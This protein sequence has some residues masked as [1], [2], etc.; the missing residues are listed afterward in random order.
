[1]LAMSSGINKS[2]DIFSQALSNQNQQASPPYMY[3]ISPYIQPQ[4]QH[5]LMQFPQ[6]QRN[7]A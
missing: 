3:Q 2:V 5:S 4:K 6:R 1:M 7:V